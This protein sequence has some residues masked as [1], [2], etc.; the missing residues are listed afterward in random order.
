MMSALEGEGK[1]VVK[2]QNKERE[3]ASI[4]Q[5]P[6]A[7]RVGEGGIKNSQNIADFI[8]RDYSIISLYE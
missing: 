2:K 4:N 6:N 7:D 8:C 3:V 1:E 5:F